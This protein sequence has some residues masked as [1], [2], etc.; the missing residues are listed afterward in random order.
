MFTEYVA[1][2]HTH[3]VLSPCASVEMIPPLIVRAALARGITLLAITDHNASANVAAVQQA[4]EG[5]ALSVLPGME[6]QT[7]E[8]VHLLCLFDTPG[9]LA[10]W[11]AE[12]NACLPDLPN[13]AEFWGEQFVVDATGDLLRREPRLLLTAAR[14]TL[15]A[16]VASVLRLGGLP[17]PAHVDRRAYGLLAQLGFVPPDLPVPGLELSRWCNPEM[18][19]ERFPQLAGYALMQN[20]DAHELGEL[21]GA[22]VLRLAAPTVGEIALAL[23]GEGGRAFRARASTADNRPCKT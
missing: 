23:R 8:D 9:Q 21:L 6:L 7:R 5:T 2:L 4:A 19:R 11:Q 16:A 15:A 10:A 1:D 17:L 13:R 18:A 20:G 12:V 14:M 22:T 3:T